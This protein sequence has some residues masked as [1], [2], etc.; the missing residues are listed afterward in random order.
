MSFFIH[1][2]F[3]PLTFYCSYPGFTFTSSLIS[4]FLASASFLR[5]AGQCHLF[6][7]SFPIILT[8]NHILADMASS[9]SLFC[10]IFLQHFNT[11]L[12]VSSFRNQTQSNF[13]L[14]S[15]KTVAL[16][17]PILLSTKNVSNLYSSQ[18]VRRCFLC[19]LSKLPPPILTLPPHHRPFYRNLFFLFYSDFLKKKKFILPSHHG[20]F[21]RRRRI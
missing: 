21:H 20:P 17:P 10:I 9:L 16:L 18:F 1:F 19:C 14:L 7:F 2:F 13:C 8:S 15:I 4:R 12:H 3:F 5:A 11:F 6:C